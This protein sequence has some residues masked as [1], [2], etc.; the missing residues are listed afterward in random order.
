MPKR[1]KLGLHAEV[2]RICLNLLSLAIR[3][4]LENRTDKREVIRELRINV[5]TLK[6]LIR[7]EFELKIIRESYYLLFEE[8]LQEISKEAL[9]WEN[10]AKKNSP[11]GE[12]F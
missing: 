3:A 11:Q 7:V 1:D 4:S 9:G 10:Y 8:K 6:Y 12:L 2:E 5:E